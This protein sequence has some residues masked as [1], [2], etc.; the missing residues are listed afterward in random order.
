[1]LAAGGVL[2]TH[3]LVEFP[4][5]Y[6]FFLLPMAVFIG[7]VESRINAAAVTSASI[8]NWTFGLS[9]AAMAAFLALVCIEYLAVEDASRRQ[10][11]K[12][13]GYV[14]RGD[15]PMIPDVH[16]LD[17]QRD[18]IWFRMT[19][20]RVGMSP[21]ELERMRQVKERFMP[22][23]V[24]LRYA[25]ATGLNG[26]EA[27]ARQALQLVCQMWQ[28]RNCDEGR[29]SW[30]ALQARFPTLRAIEF[31]AHFESAPVAKLDVAPSSEPIRTTASAQPNIP[32]SNME[33]SAN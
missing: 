7:V 1:M 22:P 10:S 23:A 15:E 18:F 16:L 28:R 4:H 9:S 29:K 8:S 33:K 13:A 21:Q 26:Q 11:F 2:L 30:A 17:N 12:E 31:P 25:I 3:A 6:A 5:A 24:L 14:V 20:A 32:S 19:E 27:Q